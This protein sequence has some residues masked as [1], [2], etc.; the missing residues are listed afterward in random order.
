[1]HLF[2]HRILLDGKVTNIEINGNKIVDINPYLDIP[3]N[4][5]VIDGTD[6]AAFPTFANLHTHA[7]MVLFRGYGDDNPLN[8]W[9]NQ[10]IWPKEKLLDSEMIYW[11]VRYA[12]IEMIKSGTTAFNDMYFFIPD[13][14][15]A[16]EDSGIRAVL[17]ECCFGDGDNLGKSGLATLPHSDRVAFA[18]NPHAIYTVSE[19]GLLST[20]EYC[21]QHHMPFHIHMS[22]TEQEVDDCVKQHGCRPFEYLDRL[23]L[24]Q[25]FGK[26]LYTAHTL[27]LSKN[28]IE[29]I[30]KYGC[31]VVHNPNSN[32]KLGS[33]HQFMYSELK[34]AGANVTLGTDGASSSNNLDML[35]A[36]K[37][38]T[39]LQKG[40]RKDPVVLPARETLSVASKN[41][42]DA[43]GINAGSITTGALADL[44]LV[45][46]NNIAFVPNN[47]TLSNLIY[48]AHSDAIDTV[49]CNGKIVMEHR[50]VEDE[51]VVRANV[52]RL[53]KKLLA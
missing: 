29:L 32:L 30:G 41:G 35:E 20:A 12:C 5:V 24:L 18:Y 22:E 39:M 53:A 36:A 52:R 48:A 21:K 14:A 38:M 25:M 9:L 2:I 3:S 6:K 8:E 33:G 15:R 7:A 46:L 4:A 27:H 34:S 10:W 31:T 43:L 49:I 51:E 16:V 45:D 44:M 17:G 42:F 26:R 50:R 11:A 23:G 40:W 28:E 47:N 37:T 19:Q 1:M 13:A